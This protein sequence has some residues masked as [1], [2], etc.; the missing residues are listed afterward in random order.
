MGGKVGRE[1]IAGANSVIRLVEKGA[2]AV[3]C[4]CRDSNHSLTDH[5][6]EAARLRHVPIVILPKSAQELAAILRI[7][8]ISCFAISLQHE[9]DFT[10]D[11]P[12]VSSRREQ[13]ASVRSQDKSHMKGEQEI[14][15]TNLTPLPAE[16]ID[17][18]DQICLDL[19]VETVET[20]KTE[21]EESEMAA[22]LIRSALIDDLRDLLIS[23][24]SMKPS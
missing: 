10:S 21:M 6:V 8:R 18:A 3:I 19:V 1:I 17:S 14:L 12:T 13:R 2:A 20:S 23:V 16:D 11:K 15:N 24:S 4:I 9:D 22:A 5:I 7:K